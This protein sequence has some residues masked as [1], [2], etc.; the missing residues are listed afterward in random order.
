MRR[1]FNISGLLTAMILLLSAWFQVGNAQV[2]S[3]KLIKCILPKGPF[4]SR[5]TAGIVKLINSGNELVWSHTDSAMRMFQAAEQD[6]RNIGYINGVIEALLSTAHVYTAQ[7]KYAESF[8]CYN[9]ALVYCNYTTDKS[10]RSRLYTDMATTYLLQSDYP[11]A[12]KY[13]FAAFKVLKENGFAEHP[14][15]LFTYANL[16]YLQSRLGQY[17]LALYYLGEAEA[18]ARKHKYYGRLAFILNNKGE[19]YRALKQ[20]DKALQCYNEG[21]EQCTKSAMSSSN[22]IVE[23][24][25]SLYISLGTLLLE[26]G[27]LHTAINYLEQAIQLSA[28]TSPYYSTIFPNYLLGKAYFGLK[29]YKNAEAHLVPAL[30]RA[31]ELKFKE[32]MPDALKTLAAVY[33]ATGRYK[34]SLQQYRAYSELKDT[35]LSEAKTREVSQLEMKY[36]TAQKDKE[37]AGKQLLILRQH[38]QLMHKNTLLL[39]LAL[40]ILLLLSGVL[41]LIMR[42]RSN[43]HYQHL[44]QEEIKS[45]AREM[46]LVKQGE[47]INVMQALIKGEERERER[48]AKELHDGVGGML[49]AIQMQFSTLDTNRD[50]DI[51]DKQINK[52][53][54]MLNDTATEIRKT[55]HNLMPDIVLKHSLEEALRLFIADINAIGKIKIDLQIYGEIIAMDKSAELNIYRI[56]QELVHNIISHSG[57]ESAVVQLTMQGNTLRIITEDNGAGFIPEQK[58]QGLGLQNI[59]S[60]V[61]ALGGYFSIDSAPGKGT[62]S[63]IEFAL[64]TLIPHTV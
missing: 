46:E 30:Q 36:R 53:V 37:I 6:S 34:A 10:M 32:D 27:N 26:Q 40:C 20:P 7:S 61:E 60:R 11:N 17:N 4:T 38:N 62:T 15:I 41:L 2:L 57:A 24:K 12:A 47:A 8:T 25:Q 63:Y 9:Q 3:D 23:V 56:I 5:D 51:K 39:I 33:E 16:A 44:Q 14:S 21:L 55:A 35:L 31:T 22:Q 28:N 45:I 18:I 64:S 59:S 19:A 58:K 49:A 54:K 29:D 50:E 52:I 1:L 43:K 13:Y 48:M 42:F